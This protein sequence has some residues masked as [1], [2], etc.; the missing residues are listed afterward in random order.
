MIVLILLIVAWKKEGKDPYRVAAAAK[1]H[2]QAVRAD[3]THNCSRK[4][5]TDREKEVQYG[6][7]V[8]PK[9]VEAVLL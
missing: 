9:L 2:C 7:R 5:G 3:F 6:E 1:K 8:K 4:E